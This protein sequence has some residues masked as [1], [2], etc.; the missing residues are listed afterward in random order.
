M[1]AT[2]IEAMLEAERLA[3]RERITGKLE[4]TL[5]AMPWLRGAEKRAIK[6]C[7]EEG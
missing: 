4:N 5:A 1:D 3:E 7:V 2:M 6:R